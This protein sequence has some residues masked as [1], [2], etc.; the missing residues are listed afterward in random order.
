M[1]Y[2]TSRSFAL[3][4]SAVLASVSLSGCEDA[5]VTDRFVDVC[6]E[7][8]EH[9]AQCT[10]DYTTAPVC[11][12]S[13]AARAEQLLALGCEQ[14]DQLSS[15]GK[16]DGAFCDWFNTNCVADE[17]I[18][19]GP[20]CSRDRDCVDGSRCHEGRCFAGV[21]SAAFARILDEQTG[22]REVLGNDVRLLAGDIAEARATWL[23]LI[24]GATHSIHVVSLIIEDNALGRDITARLVN[25]AARGVQ[26]RVMVDS[27][28]EYTYGNWDILEELAAGG[29]HV[30]AFNPITDWASLRWQVDLWANQ[31]IHEKVMVVDGR[32]AIAGG[33]NI[34]DSYMADGRWRDTDILVTGPA[35]AELQRLVL[36]DWDEFTG[37]EKLG[38]CPQRYWGAYCPADGEPARARMAEYFP[39]ATATGDTSVRV[40]HSNPRA[41]ERAHGWVSYLSAIRGA[42]TSVKIAN[43]YF[44]PPRR[45]RKHLKAAVARGVNVTVIT[46]SRTSN[47][48]ESMWYAAA[49]Y[50]RELIDAGVRICEWN[51]S[52]T[53][54]AKTMVIDDTVGFVGSYNLDPRSATTNSEAIAILRGSAVGD[55]RSAFSGDLLR[56]T[57]SDGRFGWYDRWMMSVH[58]I[59]E[60]LL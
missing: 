43:A 3:L 11:D 6:E 2:R 15:G 19:D 30:M 50:Y 48:A 10:G 17:D 46:N 35:V 52:E 7:A 56:C 9:V 41:Q 36:N 29:V 59:A 60:P 8:A 37:W 34:G 13:A 51:G 57:D 1:Q 22:A 33:R 4:V 5:P 45:L 21:G 39:A 42:Q 55:L 26:V 54:H 44:V 12:D 47:D 31:R 18:F 28:S 20:S 27:V 14:L 23:S 49:N 24:D 16:A 58:R 40:V 53:M 25:A 38:G 32:R